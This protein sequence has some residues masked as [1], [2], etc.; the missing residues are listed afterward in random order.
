MLSDVS[1]VPAAIPATNCGA[2]GL[3]Q[4]PS[5][6]ASLGGSNSP[7]QLFEDLEPLSRDRSNTWPLRRPQLDINAQT[8]P[9][10]HELIPEGEED[11]EYVPNM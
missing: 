9:L 3:M 2:G 6:M 11:N 4:P 10:I 5:V 8:S 1:P 7:D